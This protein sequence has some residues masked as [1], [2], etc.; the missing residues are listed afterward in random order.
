MSDWTL[1]RDFDG[2]TSPTRPRWEASITDGG[3]T[4]ALKE[5][6]SVGEAR[7]HY[8][9]ADVIDALQQEDLEYE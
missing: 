4:I 5:V 2:A 8:I 9:P 1:L 7:I 3:D 6:L